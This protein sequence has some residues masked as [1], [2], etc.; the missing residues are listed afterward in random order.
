MC[1]CVFVCVFRSLQLVAHAFHSLHAMPVTILRVHGVLDNRG[2]MLSS[3]LIAA[4]AKAVARATVESS[5]LPASGSGL[6][7]ENV[8]AIAE[9]VVED[10]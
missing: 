3:V 4:A 9:F 1:V 10:V 2:Q 6:R 8:D 5:S 7:G